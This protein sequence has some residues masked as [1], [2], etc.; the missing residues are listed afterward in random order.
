MAQDRQ[1]RLLGLELQQIVET[2]EKAVAILRAAQQECDV[3]QQDTACQ[4]QAEQKQAEQRL[5][6]LQKKVEADVATVIAKRNAAAK[7]QYSAQRTKLEEAFETGSKRWADEL[8]SRII[9]A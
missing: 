5:A 7:A 6:D 9:G 8:V 2:D 4:L 1:G 3:L